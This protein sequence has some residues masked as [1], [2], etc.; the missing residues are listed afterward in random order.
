MSA[1]HNLRSCSPLKTVFIK[2]G[3]TYQAYCYTYKTHA[4]VTC[5]GGAGQPLD[6]DSAQHGQDTDILNDYH[7]E[8]MDNFEKAEQ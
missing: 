7:H 6:M 2:Q 8:D 1:H 4:M 5:H 3:N